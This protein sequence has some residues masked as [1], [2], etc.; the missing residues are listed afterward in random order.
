V[1]V[2]AT[3]AAPVKGSRIK[4]HFNLIGDPMNKRA[5]V[6]W[7][8]G[9][10]CAA[11][12]GPG[13]IGAQTVRENQALFDKPDGAQMSVKIKSGS[14]VKPLKRQGF[15]VE[16]DVNGTVGWLR[17]SMLNFGGTGN[18]PTAIDTGRLGSR[19]IVSTSAARGL[20]A[21]D[22]ING[23]PN[24]E[25]LKK[26]EQFEVENSEITAFLLDGS[27]TAV[28]QKVS[29]IPVRPGAIA[30]AADSKT[31]LTPNGSTNNEKKQDDW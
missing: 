5:A 23:K 11:L 27:V 26:L 18:G 28:N 10:I 4:N 30:P 15:W 12:I 9:V 13:S 22:L 8:S 6:V 25:E 16:V 31:N 24:F 20:S 29:L 3:A 17:V 1:S 21:K 7:F 14:Q 19:N 2:K